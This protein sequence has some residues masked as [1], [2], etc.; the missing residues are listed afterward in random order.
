MRRVAGTWNGTAADV[1]LCIGFVPDW[2]KI[3]N[4]E[5]TAQ[6]QIEWSRMMLRSD[7]T[8]IEG[9]QT[10][11]DYVATE[12]TAGNGILPYYGGDLLTSSNQT[13][14]TYGEG[15]YLGWDNKDYRYL[16]N[17][18][19]GI[20]GDAADADITTWTLGSSANRT[21]NFNSDV[22]GTYI[23]PGSKILIQRPQ[24]AANSGEVEEHAINTLAAGAGV[25]ANEVTLSASMAS[26]NVRFIGGKYSMAPIALNKTTLDG[27]RVSNTTVNVNDEI[28][29]F[30]AG[31]YN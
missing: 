27:F 16:T 15:V 18:A 21:G 23:G 10:T 24:G 31:T 12:L 5:G 3:V 30:E 8:M 20:V 2:V 17:S 6:E 11:G 19:L 25:S 28:I 4:I 1:Y 13:S 22:T 29:M 9:V 7:G 26:G 14:T